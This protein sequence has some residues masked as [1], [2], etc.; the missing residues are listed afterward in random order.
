M[1]ATTFPWSTAACPC[2]RARSATAARRQRPP[3]QTCAP[4]PPTCPT[5]AA[6]RCRMCWRA[7]R[8]CR[9]STPFPAPSR[10]SSCHEGGTRP[11]RPPPRRGCRGTRPPPRQRRC[12]TT[13]SARAALRPLP[14][15][16]PP[17]LLRPPPR[18]FVC[19]R[20]CRSHRRRGRRPRRRL[21]GCRLIRHRQGCPS[22]PPFARARGGAGQPS[23]RLVAA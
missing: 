7:G 6:T 15:P 22:T 1:A 10:T 19:H 16:R 3:R 21:R 18:R 5:V 8:A 23:R 20:W 11:P 13:T 2:C 4:R 9:P 17:L 12:G 14:L